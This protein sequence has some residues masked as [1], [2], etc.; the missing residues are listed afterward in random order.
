MTQLEILELAQTALINQIIETDSKIRKGHN[1]INESTDDLNKTCKYKQIVKELCK[2]EQELKNK[3][4]EIH[5]LI[6]DEH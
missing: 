2:K 3:L 6:F 4:E 5:Q 1:M